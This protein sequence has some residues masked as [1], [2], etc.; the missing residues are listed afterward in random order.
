MSKD[1]GKY[2]KSK[3]T[4]GGKYSKVKL[5]SVQPLEPVGESGW[6]LVGDY[7]WS[8]VGFWL[9]S[10]WGF[11]QESGRGFRLQPDWGV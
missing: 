2:S 7:G 9:E 6:S 1:V 10:G 8:M 11:W 5:L 3:T 4:K